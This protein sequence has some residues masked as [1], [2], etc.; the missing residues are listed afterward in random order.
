MHVM[1]RRS[2]LALQCLFPF[3]S[4]TCAQANPAGA[5]V[6]G[7]VITQMANFGHMTVLLS[8]IKDTQAVTFRLN[9]SSKPFMCD[10]EARDQVCS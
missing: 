10:V 6:E 8:C 9:I 2:K 1:A 7:Y 4:A 5:A 3:H